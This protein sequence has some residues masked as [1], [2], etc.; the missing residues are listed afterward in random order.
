M[1]KIGIYCKD[2]VQKKEIKKSL[3]EYFDALQMEAEI[4]TLRTKVT[5]LNDI[6]ESFTDYKIILLCDEDKVSYFK[7]N[8][9]NHFKDYSNMTVGCL[10]LPLSMDKIEEIIFNEDY[11]FC[12][13]GVYK[14]ITNKT[15]RAIPYDDINFLRWNGNKTIIYLKDYE[16]EEEKKSI[17]KMKVELPEKYFV[18]SIKGYIINLYNVKKIDKVNHQ[19]VMHSGHRIPISSRKYKSFVR[20]YI[21]VM[22]GI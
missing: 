8:V 20:L 2:R 9:V 12:P 11:H 19:L 17:K 18:E 13:R 21:E 16:T 14:L 15:I 5:V 22:F 3:K 10:S 4:T 6:T 7:K 1:L